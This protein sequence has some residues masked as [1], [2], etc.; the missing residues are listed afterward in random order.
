MA[1]FCVGLQVYSEWPLNFDSLHTV[2][3]FSVANELQQFSSWD[4]TFLQCKMALLSTFLKS[5]HCELSYFY[6]VLF[7]LSFS[8]FVSN[9][10]A[11]KLWLF[12]LCSQY[13]GFDQQICLSVDWSELYT[14]IYSIIY[15]KEEILFCLLFNAMLHID[16]MSLPE[17][18]A[19]KKFVGRNYDFME[20]FLSI[21]FP[22][23]LSLEMVSYDL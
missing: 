1:V 21:Y 8:S 6:L 20:H 10:L 3:I 19:E 2:N 17:V 15:S 5:R 23:S 11:N 12:K 9:K 4:V 7:M 14:C 18:W 13:Y 22:L 16:L